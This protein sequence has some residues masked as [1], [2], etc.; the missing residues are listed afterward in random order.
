[1]LRDRNGLVKITI[2]ELKVAARYKSLGKSQSR[3]MFG[4]KRFEASYINL[5]RFNLVEYL[6]FNNVLV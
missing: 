3:R 4:G 1:M 5:P 6:V 2:P